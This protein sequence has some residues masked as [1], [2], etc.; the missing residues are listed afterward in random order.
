MTVGP[1]EDHIGV[2]VGVDVT[3]AERLVEPVWLTRVGPANDHEIRRALVV[4]VGRGADPSGVLS[5]STTRFASICSHRF[6][7]C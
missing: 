4:H 5:A 7:H 2:G 1:D 3:T 6:G